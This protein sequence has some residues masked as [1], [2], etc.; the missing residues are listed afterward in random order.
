MATTILFDWIAIA[1]ENDPFTRQKIE[2]LKEWIRNQFSYFYNLPNYIINDYINPNNDRV[3]R[4]I[5]SMDKTVYA[6]LKINSDPLPVPPDGPPPGV[7]TIIETNAF[8]L[9]SFDV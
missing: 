8:N 7:E 4:L 1:K 6:S 2:E 3:V 9:T 5:G